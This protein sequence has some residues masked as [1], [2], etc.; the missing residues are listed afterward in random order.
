ML[1]DNGSRHGREECE[2]EMCNNETGFHSD[3]SDYITSEIIVKAD[4]D[5]NIIR[6][7]MEKS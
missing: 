4:F 6:H 1:L 3:Y 7:Q 5:T 2:E